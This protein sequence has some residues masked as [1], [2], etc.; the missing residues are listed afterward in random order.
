MWS[1]ML[2]HLSVKE[3]KYSFLSHFKA[4]PTLTSFIVRKIKQKL[5]MIRQKCLSLS[6]YL[7]HLEGRGGGLLFHHCYQHPCSPTDFP[8]LFAGP[9]VSRLGSPKLLE[10]FCKQKQLHCK[11]ET[12][13]LLRW[14]GKKEII[15]YS[16]PRLCCHFLMLV[17]PAAPS[18]CCHPSGCPSEQRQ[19]VFQCWPW[20]S[21]EGLIEMLNVVLSCFFCGA[22]SINLYPLS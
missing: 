21:F 5:Q 13:D 19:T 7:V 6:K 10:L 4:N 2:Y 22:F 3:M 15:L 1:F 12:C 20:M 9:S 16:C 8:L 17:F 18:K 11:N 14:S